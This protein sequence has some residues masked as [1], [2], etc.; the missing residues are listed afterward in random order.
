MLKKTVLFICFLISALGIFVCTKNYSIDPIYSNSISGFSGPTFIYTLFDENNGE[1]VIKLYINNQNNSS[2]LSPDNELRSFARISPDGTKIAY[3]KNQSLHPWFGIVKKGTT[4]L[5]FTR[6]M[7]K[8]EIILLN[9]ESINYGSLDWINET[10][11]ALSVYMDPEY[12]FQIIN[13]AGVVLYEKKLDSVFKLYVLPNSNYVYLCNNYKFCIFNIATSEYREYP[14]NENIATYRPPIVV[15]HELIIKLVDN[16]YLK[17][18]LDTHSYETFLTLDYNNILIMMNSN[19]KVFLQ[20]GKESKLVLYQNDEMQKTIAMSNYKCDVGLYL[21]EDHILYFVGE[22]GDDEGGF[23][24]ADFNESR[25][26]KLTN[27]DEKNF[28]VD[29][30]F[31]NFN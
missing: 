12:Y 23:F 11:I 8:T 26:T 14:V 7:G 16:T 28:I 10:Q 24:K 27:H 19:E 3:I 30:A 15:N 4:A 17:Y 25:I 5:C 1:N 18:D 21:S 29:F 2:L 13:I 22:V 6:D 9:D 20:Q 31:Y